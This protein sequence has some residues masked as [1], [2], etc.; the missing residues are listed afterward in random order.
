MVDSTHLPDESP[1]IACP[2]CSTAVTAETAPCPTC[3]AILNSDEEHHL[4]GVTAIDAAIARGEKRPP[5]KGRFLSWFGGESPDEPT[6]PTDPQAIAPP[7]DDVQRE[8]LRLQLAAQ[9][10]NLQAEADSILSDALVEGRVA[11]LP[12]GLRPLAAAEASAETPAETADALVEAAMRAGTAVDIEAEA[13]TEA[14]QA[15]S[16]AAATEVAE[17][18]RSTEAAEAAPK[19]DE[20]G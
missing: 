3:D 11:D 19:A 14:A 15:T 13:D 16:A 1:D 2:W 20:P 6:T 8:I 18:A 10:S 17:A 5:Q 4:P 7:D 12:D 9:I